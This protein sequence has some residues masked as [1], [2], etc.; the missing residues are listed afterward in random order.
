MI[1]LA[2]VLAGGRGER[3]GGEIP[4]QFCRLLNKPLLH[5]CLEAFEFMGAITSMVV[6]MP[7][8][9]CETVQVKMDLKHF[10][11]IVAIVPGGK[12]RQ[13]S[14][15][16]GLLALPEDTEYVVI[17]DGAR[18]FPPVKG[19]KNAIEA[20]RE[21][22]AAILACPITDT[23][24]K[25][26]Q[27]NLVTETINREGLWVAQTPQVFRKDLIIEAYR[28]IR[29]KAV[30]VTDDAAAVEEM[31]KPVRLIP[32][33]SRN[34]KITVKRDFGVARRIWEGMREEHS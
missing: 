10:R 21:C 20:A 1:A 2:L 14:V 25:A 4:K 12:K 29:K 6:V 3:V 16:N 26:D 17:H 18:P 27:E 5:Y 9:Y 33:T 23:V 30:V 11:K 34:V 7:P 24:K 8:E 15:I 13:D 31:G 32:S 28:H 19:T 22:G